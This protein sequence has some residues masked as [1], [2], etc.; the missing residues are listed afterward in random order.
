MSKM[1]KIK[2]RPE[3]A[4]QVKEEGS[5]MKGKKTNQPTLSRPEH[6]YNT[7]LLGKK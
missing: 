4:V 1:K 6:T 5:D 7:Q 2:G 3:S